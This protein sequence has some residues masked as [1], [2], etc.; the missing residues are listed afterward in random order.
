[1]ADIK[2]L[3]NI[4]EMKRMN[5]VEE[6]AISYIQNAKTAEDILSNDTRWKIFYHFAPMRQSLFNWIDF[7]MNTELLEIG[8]ELGVLTS[9]F[10]QK[11]AR[12]TAVDWLPQYAEATCVRN[13]QYE[14]L[15][16]YVGD[17]REYAG[18]KKYDYIIMM[19]S[20]YGNQLES[21]LGFLKS[22]LK[23]DGTI[24]IVAKNR[25]GAD[26]VSGKALEGEMP[27][28]A[29]RTSYLQCDYYSRKQL[30]DILERTQ[31][32]KTK[33]YYPVPDYVLPQEIY[34]EEMLP[35]GKRVDRVL[36][37]FPRKDT[38]LFHP[39]YYM[40]EMIDNHIFEQCANSFLIECKESGECSAIS[41]V[42]LSTDRERKNAYA[43]KIYGENR[44]RKEPLFEE[45][46]VGAENLY[47]N[48]EELCRRGIRVIEHQKDEKSFAI[49]MP[50]VNNQSLMQYIGSEWKNKEVLVGLFDEFW[51]QILASSNLV[52]ADHNA[53]LH[54]DCQAEW[55]PIL[56]AA[57]IDMIPL[58]CFWM[59]GQFAFFDQ[60]FKFENYP[61]KYVLFRALRY[62]D[63]SLKGDGKQF[64]LEF[65]KDRYQ[66]GAVWDYCLKEEDE[67]I[68]RNRNHALYKN[69]YN[70]ICLTD[71]DIQRNVVRLCYGENDDNEFSE[72]FQNLGLRVG[73][74]AAFY[75][76]ETS[77]CG[78]WRWVNSD[79][80]EIVLDYTGADE[81]HFELEFEIIFPD[82]KERKKVDVY[83]DGALWGSALAPVKMVIPIVMEKNGRTHIELKG[84][85]WEMYFPNDSRTFRYQFR[86]YSIN[87]EPQYIDEK[88][89][90]VRKVQIE[91]LEKVKEVCNTNDLQYFAIYGTLLGTVRNEGYIPWDD[92]ID[93]AMPRRDYNVLL[94]LNEEEHIFGEKYFLQNLYS[95]REAFFGGYSKLRNNNTTGITRQ[96]YGRM[97][98]QGIWIDIFPLD[99]CVDDMCQFAIQHRKINFYQ[100]ILYYKVYKRI[101]FRQER[102]WK[103][104]M[105]ILARVLPWEYLCEKLD[106]Y[107]QLY[108]NTECKNV[109]V[110][111]RIMCLEEVPLLPRQCFD[112]WEIRKF[113]R[114]DMP[115]PVL[116]DECL[117]R[118]Y[119]IGYMLYPEKEFRKT[120]LEAYFDVSKSYRLS[121]SEY[122]NDEW[123]N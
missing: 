15:S 69:L 57:Y 3:G 9:L 58:N 14:N 90:A 36:N 95:E 62:T 4:G 104:Y 34:S 41:Y 53:M 22:L 118:F 38:M 56:G 43:T 98:N 87:E 16:V 78:I 55:G 49:E 113:E 54:Y 103:W 46:R 76:K 5:V 35:K 88:T 52:S 32:K 63:I 13:E 27:Y 25:I 66:L 39:A 112:D 91:L 65:Y 23:S 114:A 120:H 71:D 44:V 30:N 61:A 102:R 119:G 109:A 86:N 74:S 31:L 107:I 92:D 80:A 10:C 37:Y 73:F 6:D 111:S 48:I 64:D 115:I 122:R 94:Q 20:Y 106:Y 82:P 26:V 108:N 70:W 33:F 84:K 40:D 123:E 18:N 110:L 11:C 101:A 24:Y 19:P 105:K 81:K 29:L 116:Y 77:D 97:A 2:Y 17:I 1:M 42:A 28:E 12:V 60:E 121:I 99:N 83:I 93:I 89:K 21:M 7:K 45:G 75:D 67:F 72:E 100:N 51:Q 50:Y 47:R 59:D 117:K 96:N 8:C 79:N 68:Y 85:M